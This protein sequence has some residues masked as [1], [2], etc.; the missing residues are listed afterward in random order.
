MLPSLVAQEIREGLRQYLVTGFEPSNDGFRGIVQA[1]VDTPGNLDKGP[2]LSLGLPFRAGTS[3]KDF[4]SGFKTE[5]PPFVHQEIAWQRLQT[6]GGPESTLIA[7]GTGSGKTECF[8]YPLLDHCLREHLAGRVDGIKALIIYPMNA[9]GSDQAR[10]FAELIHRNTALHGRLR[11]GL[12]IGE[13]EGKSAG[14]D[15]MTERN[16]IT[17]KEALREHPPDILLTKHKMLD[18]LLIRPKDRA[19]WRH[20]QASTLRY[21]VVDELHTFDGAQGTDLALL[22]RRVKARLQTPVRHLI[23]IGT[24]ATLG[25]GAESAGLI[26]Y[27]SD[28]FGEPFDSAAVI[29]EDR[30]SMGDFVAGSLIEHQ[31]PADAAADALL[32][33]LAS[34]DPP[35]AVA[36][37]H[38]VFFPG[39]G[40]SSLP[41]DPPWRSRLGGQLKGQLQF[42]NLLR[43]LNGRLRSLDDLVAEFP[44]FLPASLREHAAESLLALL[45]LVAW[46]R[47]PHD[48]RLPFVHV[49]LQLWLR[50]QRRMVV[51]LAQKPEDRTLHS[52]DDLADRSGKIFLPL[53]QCS[54]CRTAGWL[55][56][57]APADH[58]IDLRLQGIYDAFFNRRADVALLYPAADLSGT[59]AK[60]YTVHVCGGCG[61]VQSTPAACQ[62]C[63]HQEVVHVFRPNL[64]KQVQR[65]SGNTTVSEH[66]CSTCGAEDTLLLFGA[67]S[68]SLTAVAL[69]HLWG[70]SANDQRKAIAFSDSVQD[71]AHRAG[72]FSART[73]SACV[74]GA[75]VQALEA[76]PEGTIAWQPFLDRLPEFW[77]TPEANPKAMPPER[78]VTEFIGPNMQWLDEYRD[79]KET[80]SLR[81][82]WLLDAVRKRLQ[83]ETLAGF[84]YHARRGR[85]IERVG[86]AALGIHPERVAQAATR[87]AAHLAGDLG[88]RNLTEPMVR[89]FLWGFLWHLKHR[90]AIDHPFMST[91]IEQGGRAYLL[92]RLPFLPSFGFRSAR[93]LFLSLAARHPEFDT[94]AGRQRSTWYEGWVD[95]CLGA[96]GLLPAGIAPEIYQVVCGA[97]RQVGVLCQR[98]VRDGPVVALNPEALFIE[99]SVERLAPGNGAEIVVPASLGHEFD[100]MPAVDLTVQARY[101]RRGDS[102]HW[103]RGVYRNAEIRRIVAAEHTGLLQRDEREALEARFKSEAAVPWHENLLSATPTLEMG[104][105]IG[106]LSS[107]LLCSVPPLQANYLQRIGRAGRRDGNALALTVAAGKPHDLYFYARPEE[108]MAGRVQPP[109]VF[110]NASAV[111]F[112][113]LMAFCLD[114]WVGTGVDQTGFPVT[115][116]PVL[117]AVERYE[118]QKFPYNFIDFVQR[119]AQGLFAQFAGLLG[120]GVHDRTLSALEGFL[121]GG[122]ETDSLRLRLLKKLQAAVEERKGFAGRAKTLKSEID[123]LKRAPQDEAT[124][125]RMEDAT[126]ER[127]VLL[128]INR[129]TN[130]RD[131]L[132]FM[133][134]EGLIP[135]YAFPEEGV[136]LRSVLWWRRR[137]AKQGE[138]R[139]D[140]RIVEY[141]RGASAA[142]SELAPL[143]HFFAG[144]HRVRVDQIDLRLSSLESWRFC[145]SCSH[146]EN[147][148]QG[149]LHSQCPR[150]G[151]IQWADVGQRMYLIRLRHVMANDED[152]R[153]RIDDG[154]DDRDYEF[155][156]R[157]LLPDFVN[158]DIQLAYR[159]AS[160]HLPFG[161]EFIRKVAFRDINFGRFAATGEV[162]NVAGR[163]AVRR[164]FRLCRHCGKVQ[165]G[166]SDLETG[167]EEQVHAFDCP[168]KDGSKDDAIIDCLYLYREFYSEAL[169]ILLPMTETDTDS[170][171]VPSL[172]AAI[173]LGLQL[174][175]GGRVDHLE[176][177]SYSEPDRASGATRRYLMLYDSVPGGTG[178]LHELLRDEDRLFEV[179]Q[180]A[181]DHMVACACTQEADLD[182][183]YRCLYAYRLSSGMH[184]TS[185]TR[186]V[187]LLSEILDSRDKLERVS[188]LSDI[189]VNPSFDSAL[190]ARV[191]EA[192]KR[193]SGQD[194]T[195]RIQPEIVRGK[196]GYYLRVG[197]NEY[198]IE[199]Q[200]LLGPS[201]GVAVPSKPDFLIRPARS[202]ST[203]LPLALFADGFEHHKGTLTEDTRKRLALVQSGQFWVWALTWQD[204]EAAL[205]ATD[206]DIWPLPASGNDTL[207][208]NATKVANA[209]GVASTMTKLRL[210]PFQ[211]LIEWLRAP[212]AEHWAGAVFARCLA[213]TQKG[214]TASEVQTLLAW[215]RSHLPSALREG[216]D[217]GGIALCG[218]IGVGPPEVR[219][220]LPGG[221]LK[222][223][224]PSAMVLAL[225]LDGQGC[226]DDKIL[227]TAWRR[228]LALSNL[229]QFLPYAAA[230]TPQGLDEGLYEFPRW[231]RL[232]GADAS[233]KE[234]LPNEWQTAIDEAIGDAEE[235]LRALFAAGT[236]P[237]T[238]GYELQ[239][240]TGV[241]VAEG[242]LA[243]PLQHVT[244]LLAEAAEHKAIW[245]SRGWH[246][247]ILRD[248]W[249][250]QVRRTWDGS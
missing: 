25:D 87:A 29:G 15:I 161:F 52:A 2:Y 198:T 232:K 113:Q 48:P 59:A 189:A 145:P 98:D 249:P 38:Q 117:D 24:S 168:A 236:P 143:N 97:L 213:W 111:L 160:E 157:Q 85:S 238:V 62:N 13:G 141:E 208:E 126:R 181:R 135:N 155:Y 6:A 110:L 138:S 204:I 178:Y 32:Q 137:E 92:Q 173:R 120:A 30:L 242:E 222:S 225:V 146:G 73:Y 169:R 10:R 239:D 82:E 9:L 11:V 151:D 16:V 142:L 69:Q 187:A 129:A 228:F 193:C 31:L 34:T 104:V 51:R 19:L 180:L 80:G 28:V 77:V 197:G 153:S 20:N 22:I 68:T 221:A 115:L 224:Q 118:P 196:A 174:R 219:W 175:F 18:Y 164:G 105:D 167:E 127:N 247:V 124:V 245:E 150:C 81:G 136:T 109:G 39:D 163:E 166:A 229:V 147:L 140:H 60:G 200:V 35:S 119:E 95:K 216:V 67:R 182:G 36:A 235:G 71:A 152:T 1:F 148:A 207:D 186:A 76:E 191:I 94:V 122:D 65:R 55:T 61:H 108:M 100:G 88:L 154:S 215:I 246:A 159:I 183:C 230:V 99:R 179:F 234:E 8:L 114:A 53:V 41:T 91:Y 210:S 47:D 243:W 84:S 244:V 170:R 17:S 27:A 21:L 12:Y 176:M 171:T 46:A 66:V 49:R 121:F 103:L 177:V 128:D 223:L 5:H 144:G 86:C 184:A 93:P 64:A 131:L 192:F 33:A 40:V 74:H 248:G 42:N 190:E 58:Q 241:V 195:V 44:R 201:D 205:G 156:N 199:P 23:C 37:W 231:P 54:E 116:S 3:G 63:G 211:Q 78:F 233:V 50:E 57:I 250:E 214:A 43:L 202:A 217:E 212:D 203:A 89:H 139:Y 26:Q 107:V 227:R 188:A 206:G 133:T 45:G 75:I 130:A 185:R 106:S 226:G 7:T 165:T 134:D 83:W 237:P 209:L 240:E 72:F 158:S 70:S 101:V 96:A 90:G 112:R 125:E 123:K 132:N 149:D 218:K 14:A 56:R 194:P 79:L 4:F 162:S 172:M 220:T 102:G